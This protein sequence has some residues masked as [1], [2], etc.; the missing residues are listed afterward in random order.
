MDYRIYVVD[1]RDDH[2]F[3]RATLLNIGA[4]EAMKHEQYQCFIFH[5]VDLLPENDNNIYGC[6]DQPKHMSVDV[7]TLN[8]KLYHEK[9]FGGV[10]QMS[11]PKF[12]KVNGYS[13]KFWGWGAEDDNMASRILAQGWKI[14]RDPPLIARYTM[15]LS[16]KRRFEMKK[17]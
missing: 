9:Q 8:Y 4:V 10:S 6:T 5:N 15:I 7:S 3:N 12:Y 1:Q 16:I 17:T 11:V 14:I 13:N 2:P